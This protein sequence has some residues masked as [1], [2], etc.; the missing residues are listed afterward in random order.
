MQGKLFGK[1][2]ESLVAASQRTMR[3]AGDAGGT[4]CPCCSKHVQ[5]YRR[6]LN[7]GMVRALIEMY[8]YQQLSGSTWIDIKK[9]K[10]V[11]GGD[12]AKLRFWGLICKYGAGEYSYEEKWSGHWRIAVKGRAFVE[13]QLTV[14]RYVT[15]YMSEVREG[16]FGELIYVDTALG[17]RFN[18]EELLRGGH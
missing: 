4:T 12:Y 15:E 8:R 10:S 13:N 7:S 18:R 9:V 1:P 17:S 14:P 11:R 5:I 16:P 3:L 2:G 6:T